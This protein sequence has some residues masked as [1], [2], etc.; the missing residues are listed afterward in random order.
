MEDLRACGC[1]SMGISNCD[2][3]GR[4]IKY[5]ENYA[6]VSDWAKDRTTDKAFRYCA[7][8]AVKLG[9]MK[10]VRD[11]KTGTVFASTFCLKGEEIV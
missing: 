11:I 5:L 4:A 3:C 8:C 7:E 9:W 2:N 10:G 1:I 6:Y